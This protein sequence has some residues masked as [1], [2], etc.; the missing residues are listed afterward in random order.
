VLLVPPDV[1]IDSVG[2]GKS[3]EQ[4]PGVIGMRNA[5]SQSSG[6]RRR[7]SGEA[8]VKAYYVTAKKKFAAALAL[9]ESVVNI[10]LQMDGAYIYVHRL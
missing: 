3:R 4:R 8:D 2:G 6:R 1:Q 5:P 7:F 10:D 9:N